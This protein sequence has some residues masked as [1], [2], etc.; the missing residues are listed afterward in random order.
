MTQKHSSGMKPWTHLTDF[1]KPFDQ[2]NGAVD[3]DSPDKHDAEDVESRMLARGVASN[4]ANVGL[5][6]GF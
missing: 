1:E 2:T 3:F 4:A 6:G 5:T